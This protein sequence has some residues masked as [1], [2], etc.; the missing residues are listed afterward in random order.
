MGVELC[1]HLISA[2]KDECGGHTLVDTLNKASSC[3]S[4]E[5]CTGTSVHAALALGAICSRN[6]ASCAV[7]RSCKGLSKVPS[8]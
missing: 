6:N 7:L 3:S 5:E 8:Q 2:G 1:I 4:G